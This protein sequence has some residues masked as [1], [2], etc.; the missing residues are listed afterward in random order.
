MGYRSEVILAL[1][2]EVVPALM[3]AFAKNE[4][5]AKLCTQYVDELDT[6]YEGTGSWLMR[7]E[8]IKWYDSYPEIRMIEN[9]IE[10]LEADELDDFGIKDAGDLH[11]MFRFVRIGEDLSDTEQRGY[12]FDNIHISR[13]ISF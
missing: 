8:S 4:E 12:G 7:W 13:T 5:V 11:D 10:C 3:T 9:L 6:N 1:E 2:A